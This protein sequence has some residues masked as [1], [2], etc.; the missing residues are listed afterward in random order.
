MAGRGSTLSKHAGPGPRLGVARERDGAGA[1]SHAGTRSP[2][3]IRDSDQYTGGVRQ[4]DELGREHVVEIQRARVLAAMVEVSAERGAENVSVAHVVDRAGVSRR[5]FYE[6]FVDGEDCFVAAF[7]T[8]IA[9]ASRYVLDSHDPSAKWDTRVRGALIALLSFLASEPDTARLLIVGSLGA[10]ST[11]LEHRRHVLAR[12]VAVVDE[13][14][15]E[16]N[17]GERLAPLTAE[18]VVGGALSVLHSR[19]SETPA[20]NTRPSDSS[21]SSTVRGR[22]RGTDNGSPGDDSLLALTGPLM[23]MIVLPYLGPAAA[24]RELA[25]A[26]PE[27]PV[28][29]RRAEHSSLG[30]LDMRLT[31]RTVRVLLA[32]AEEPGSSNRHLGDAAGIGDQGQ[33]SKL[34][35]RLQRLG[36]IE[37]NGIGAATRGEPNAWTL[38]EQGTAVHDIIAS[39]EDAGR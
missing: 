20:T 39:V 24:R 10:G 33:A 13:G 26:V 18:G 22:T 4:R 11:V 28:S 29:A 5:T 27:I 12:I 9:R 6:L 38:T 3:S 1:H 31:Y 32:V 7:D 2:A 35:Q 23:S 17:A 16:T 36:L 21:Q 8:G 30:E 19:L 15:A 34:L 37:N 25:R 14:R